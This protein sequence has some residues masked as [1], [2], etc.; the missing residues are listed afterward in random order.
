ME[1][2]KQI[3]LMR[4]TRYL[5]TAAMVWALA[6]CA[7]SGGIDRP[8]V[9]KVAWFS[10]LN[11][12]D[13]RAAC[14]PGSA[15]QYRLVYNGEYDRQVRTYEILDAPG[16]AS[17]LARVQQG[18]GIDLINFS[19]SR[20]G[21]AGGWRSAEAALSP[22]QMAELDA[23]LAADGA[24]RPAPE[25]LRLAS[26]EFY[27]LFVGC[28]NGQVQFHAWPYAGGSFAGLRF[29]EILLRDDK[30]GIALNPPR[31]VGPINRTQRG[32]LGENPTP[33]FDISIQGNGL[34]GLAPRI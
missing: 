6:A 12:D 32:P 4:P 28:R 19:F 26:E 20:P 8:L 25:G 9:Q 14:V 30:T 33:R 7:Y 15:N 17:F 29:P 22:A 13:I 34:W 24:F 2:G 10:Y 16:G 11:G 23:A 31:E 18:G 21:G 5:L 27:W 3:M 1:Q